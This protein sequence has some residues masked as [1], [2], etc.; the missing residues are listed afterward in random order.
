MRWRKEGYAALL[1]NS[2]HNGAGRQFLT[3]VVGVPPCAGKLD[4]LSSFPGPTAWAANSLK[5]KSFKART[6]AE[7]GANETNQ[8]LAAAHPTL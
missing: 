7:A 8:K 1:S 2:R 4:L 5:N 6:G 3:C